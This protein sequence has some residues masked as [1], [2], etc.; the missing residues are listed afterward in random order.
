MNLKKL[1]PFLKYSVVT[2]IV[3]LSPV[4]LFQNCSQFSDP[5]DQ[6][7]SSSRG[8]Q[9]VSQA[10]PNHVPDPEL[11]PPA[12]QIRIGN[13]RYMME[14]FRSVFTAAD[15]TK[16]PQLE[17]V[18]FQWAERRGAQLGGGCD[19]NDSMTLFDCNDDIG[20][21]GLPIHGDSNA[22][23]ESFK[24]QLCEELIG[25]TDGLK[26]S[27]ENAG[28]NVASLPDPTFENMKPVYELFYRTDEVPSYF[29]QTMS[30]LSVDL[31]SKGESSPNI[32]R[33]LMLLVCESPEWQ[34]TEL[35][36]YWDGIYNAD[37]LKNEGDLVFDSRRD[38]ADK[39]IF[40][41]EFTVFF[42]VT[43]R[44][45]AGVFTL[46]SDSDQVLKVTVSGSKVTLTHE[47]PANNSSETLFSI[48][49]SQPVVV[50]ARSGR[51]PKNIMLMVNGEYRSVSIQ[52]RGVPVNFS[53]LEHQIEV[54]NVQ[55]SLIFSRTME[56]GEINVISRQLASEYQIP[57]RTSSNMPDYLVWTVESPYFPQVRNIMKN[58]CFRCHN[59]WISLSEAG[60]KTPSRYTKNIQLVKPKSLTESPFWHSLQ[61]S[62][63]EN[64][65]ATRDMPK[66]LP[67]LTSEQLNLI[68][69]WIFAIP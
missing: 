38:P 29:L 51:D 8:F 64:P 62:T 20:S 58:S 59:S 68:K 63:D 42:V 25:S 49:S 17:S 31:R 41:D 69:N 52:N 48:T 55:E 50:S 12:K 61:G 44:T 47:A 46:I 66:D 33:G 24:I 54:Q 35:Q 16:T 56:P 10:D 13:R 43:N 26:V 27:L 15:G 45:R 14:V 39:K 23:R 2:L 9:V 65:Q 60:F 11:S 1:T 18:L 19:A 3:V 57:T 34:Q 6:D 28:L 5:N 4:F 21:T 36:S 30:Q 40:A 37:Q 67:A 32:W 7:S 53:Y 22:V